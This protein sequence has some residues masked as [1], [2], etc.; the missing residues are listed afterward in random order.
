MPLPGAI[1]PW[2]VVGVDPGV[3]GEATITASVE[4]DGLI[5]AVGCG[6]EGEERTGFPAWTTRNAATWRQATGPSTVGA[7]PATCLQDVVSTSFGLFAHGLTLFHSADGSDWTPVEFLDPD[8]YPIGYVQAVYVADAGL[9]VLLQR[10]AQAESTIAYLFTTTDGETWVE[11]PREKAAMFDSGGVA[12][13]IATEAGL[14]AVGASPWGEFVP[15]AAV[16]VSDD[17]VDWRLV[18]PRGEGFHEAYMVDVVDTGHGLVAVGGSPFD[19]SLMAA[20][21]S[22]DGSAWE[23][24]PS[25]SS[26]VAAEHGYMEALTI[27]ATADMF[28]AF[29]RDFDAGRSVFQERN[30]LWSS[31]DGVEWMRVDLDTLEDL[32]PFSISGLGHTEVG[33]WPPPYWVDDDWVANE[34]VRVLIGR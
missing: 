29:G 10:G 4:I 5:V 32:V 2:T 19:T 18:T 22:A 27:T 31:A 12:A 17:G 33:F 16:W 20:W 24:L 8:G 28:Y 14:V 13:V 6:R 3:F 9:A 1:E 30:A 23:R 34:A 15:T 25:P 26:D 11:A 21:I 7:Y